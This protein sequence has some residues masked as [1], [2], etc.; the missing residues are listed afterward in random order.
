L[1]YLVTV[2]KGDP[3]GKKLEEDEFRQLD[4]GSNDDVVE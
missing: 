3:M 1:K 2:S 4:D